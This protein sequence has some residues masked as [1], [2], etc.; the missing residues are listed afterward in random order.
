M[1]GLVIDPVTKKQLLGLS[2]DP[3]Q[4]MLLTG[5]S[6]VGL[7]TIALEWARTISKN[8]GD[9][10]IL[11]P[12]EKGT[13]TIENIRSLYSST[14]A[15]R[16]S[17][18]TVIIDDADKMG[19]DAQ[20]AFLK[21]LE[22]PNSS[23]GFIL[24]SHT[25]GKLLPT[26]L[27]RLNQV[28]IRAVSEAESRVLLEN[29]SVTQPR[30]KSQIMFLA[31]G[32]PAEIVR[33]CDN[34]TYRSQ[35]LEQAGIAKEFVTGTRFEQLQLIAKLTSRETAQEVIRLAIR[36]VSAQLDKNQ[37]EPILNKLNAMLDVSESLSQNG[38]V[39]TQLLR[40][41]I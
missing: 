10:E 6:G 35:K 5:E 39:R 24:T 3:P 11:E 40:L 1:R 37:N 14:R 18:K 31:S 27:S 15:R 26:V 38:H 36:M 21:L 20:N 13:I 28:N 9:V 25:P 34:E 22:E 8:T 7:K 30:L 2:S 29:Y 16:E 17:I 23:T 33:L 32:L 19:T 41:V 12:N 4:A